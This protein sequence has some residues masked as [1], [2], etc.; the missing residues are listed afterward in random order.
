MNGDKTAT[1]VTHDFTPAAGDTVPTP[2]Q[3]A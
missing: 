3:T 2:A 1:H